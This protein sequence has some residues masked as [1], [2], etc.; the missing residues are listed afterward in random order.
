M[1][2]MVSA[3]G[4][5]Q[6]RSLVAIA[7]A[8]ALASCGAPTPA[9]RDAAGWVVPGSIA[10]AMHIPVDGTSQWLL[11][12]GRDARAPALLICMAARG[13]ARPCC[14]AAS[15]GRHSRTGWSSPT[16]PARRGTV[17]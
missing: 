10:E 13:R 17:P 16:G 5:I 12:R 2:S 14:S 4:V 8:V 3:A 9:F 6:R 7:I 15:S 11:L 1:G